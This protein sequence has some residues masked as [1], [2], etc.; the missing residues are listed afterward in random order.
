MSSPNPLNTPLVQ[1]QALWTWDLSGVSTGQG[2]VVTGYGYN[3][4]VTKTGLLPADLQSFIG[5]PLNQYGNPPVAIPST[6]L[7]QWIR[8]AEDWVEQKTSLLLTPTWVAAPPT[9]LPSQTTATGLIVSGAGNVQQ[10]GLDYDLYDAPYDF[11]FP[12]AQDEGWMIQNLRYRPVKNPNAFPNTAEMQNFSKF[13]TG[14]KGIAYMYPLLE[15]FF[16]VPPTWF[17]EDADMGL[18]RLVPAQNVQMLPLFAMQLAFMGFAESIPGGLWFQ[19]T[20]G[21]N[22]SDYNSR[23]SFI[24]QLVLSAASIQALATMQGTI[25]YG[26]IETEMTVDGARYKTAYDKAGPFDGLIRRFTKQRDELLAEAFNKVSGP[27]IIT[28]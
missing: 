7:I 11:F 13:Y 17:V 6:T 3:S 12:R 1:T 4:S 23:Y 14:T 26:A 25:N 15:A 10:E 2:P 24:N 28:I 20:A 19:Y 21:L 22:R 9:V 5:I 27:M 18:V 8:Y 16:R